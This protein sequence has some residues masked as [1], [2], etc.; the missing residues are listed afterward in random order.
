MIERSQ[1]T[2]EV[3]VECQ[4]GQMREHFVTYLT[5]LGGEMITVPDFPA[6]VCDICGRREYD[7][8]A[9][10]RLSLLL[11]PSA[12]KSNISRKPGTIPPVQSGI[13]YPSTPPDQSG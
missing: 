4:A 9:L 12:G 5:W 6:W 10:S 3:C 1:Q 13:D 7:Q 2:T 8:Q 11:N